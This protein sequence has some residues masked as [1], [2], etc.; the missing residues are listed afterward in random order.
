VLTRA[1]LGALVPSRTGRRT[2]IGDCLWSEPRCG[3][4][5]DL[6]RNLFAGRMDAGTARRFVTRMGARFLVADCTT[7]E[8]IP[9]LLG[10]LI[11]GSRRFGCATAYE[12]RRPHEARGPFAVR[13]AARR[14]ALR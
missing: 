3:D 12:L 5:N 2:L 4:R 8:N 6:T 1:Y 13:V 7:T 11:V 14:H 9:R 10:P